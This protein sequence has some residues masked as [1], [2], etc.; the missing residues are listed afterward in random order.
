MLPIFDKN[1]TSRNLEI[2][3]SSNK[4]EGKLMLKETRLW[5]WD[6]WKKSRNLL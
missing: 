6:G 3:R 5:I 1:E 4:V 2:S